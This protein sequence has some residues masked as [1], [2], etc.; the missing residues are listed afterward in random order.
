MRISILIA[1]LLSLSGCSWFDTNYIAPN[2]TPYLTQ[3][4]YPSFYSVD[5]VGDTYLSLI[6]TREGLS[7]CNNKLDSIRQLQNKNQEL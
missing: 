6:S 3:K 2:S 4:V 7:I 1:L 5:T